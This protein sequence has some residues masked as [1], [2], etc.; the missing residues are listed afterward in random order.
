MV[1]HRKVCRALFTSFFVTSIKTPCASRE[2][3]KF[4]PKKY[5]V[6][7]QMR[8]IWTPG[9]EMIDVVSLAII[10]T[11]LRW[12]KK[13]HDFVFLH[14]QMSRGKFQ[15]RKPGSG[16]W[17][18]DFI[19]ALPWVCVGYH[20]RKYGYFSLPMKPQGPIDSMASH[21]RQY[22]QIRFEVWIH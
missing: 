14:Y 9:A 17:G 15:S 2:F 6:L 13:L 7:Q 5:F 8:K 11:I 19:G 4:T 1:Q 18:S 16:F 10:C 22:G 21:W 12:C 3:R 20:S